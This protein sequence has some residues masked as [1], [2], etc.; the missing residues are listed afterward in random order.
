MRA[1]SLSDR[2]GGTG[3]RTPTQDAATYGK[4]AEFLSWAASAGYYPVYIAKNGPHWYSA[5]QAYDI[6]D[7]NLLNGV[8]ASEQWLADTDGD[9]WISDDERDEDADGLTNV[10]EMR[11][12]MVPEYWK[13]CYAVITEG[14][15][16]VH[17][18]GVDLVNSDTD[19]DGIRDGADDQDHDDIPNVMELSRFDASG[20]VDAGGFVEW[21]LR[22]GHCTVRDGLM[23]GPDI[24]GDGKGDPVVLHDDLDDYGRVNPFNPCQPFEWAR[25][26]PGRTTFGTKFA[27]YDGSPWY[28]LQ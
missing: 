7:V 3:R 25:T 27:P 14:E 17:Y 23:N 21:N 13:K 26:C 4:S 12:R 20:G 22:K 5:R 16:P 10:D 24:D 15:Y 1:Q 6:R 11:S 8:E 2:A 28:S 19:G 18:A 9:G